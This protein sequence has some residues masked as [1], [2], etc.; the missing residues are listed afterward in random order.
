MQSQPAF[1]IGTSKRD[2]ALSKERALLPD[3]AAYSPTEEFTKTSSAA[4][5]FGTSKRDSQELK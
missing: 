5:G 2:D 3:P 4:F 1:K